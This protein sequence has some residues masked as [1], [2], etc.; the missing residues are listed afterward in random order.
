M[1]YIGHDLINIEFI[2]EWLLYFTLVKAFVK[3]V[4]VGDRGGGKI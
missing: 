2:G 1:F 4:L 3:E